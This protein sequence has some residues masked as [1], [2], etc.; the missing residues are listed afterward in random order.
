MAC[1]LQTR[2]QL[3]PEFYRVRVAAWDDGRIVWSHN[4][5]EGGTPYFSGRIDPAKV[6]RVF[7]ILHTETSATAHAQTTYAIPD[8][9]VTTIEMR[10]K[11]PNLQIS[12]TSAHPNLSNPRLRFTS[13]GVS[14][15][16]S[17]EPPPDQQELEYRRFRDD[18]DRMVKAITEMLPVQD[19]R[20]KRR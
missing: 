18:F 20:F 10:S 5:D 19:V 4:V 6:R 15:A 3:T 1:Q 12:W 16:D 13:R 2:Q 14:G 11:T 9:A 7:H 17:P 8:A